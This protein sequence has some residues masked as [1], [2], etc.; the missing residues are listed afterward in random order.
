MTCDLSHLNLQKEWIGLSATDKLA[1]S[2]S[3]GRHIVGFDIFIGSVDSIKQMTEYH[4]KST[5]NKYT[6]V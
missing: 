4:L 2:E 1:K 3:I 5:G 6:L